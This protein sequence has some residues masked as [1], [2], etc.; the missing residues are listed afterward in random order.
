[1]LL[2]FST[3]V[4]ASI[5]WSIKRQVWLH[6]PPI[7]DEIEINKLGCM[8]SINKTAVIFIGSNIFDKGITK[9]NLVLLYDF[10]T[11]SWTLHSEYPQTFGYLPRAVICSQAADK[12]YKR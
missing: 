6:G 5:L 4:T 10:E 2:L 1:M 9:D 8:M 3:L 7:P 11:N 12:Y